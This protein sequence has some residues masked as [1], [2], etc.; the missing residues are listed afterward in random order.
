MKSAKWLAVF[1]LF[2][3]AFIAINAFIASW[4]IGLANQVI[5]DPSVFDSADIIALAREV[6]PALLF[7]IAQG[8]IF[9]VLALVAAYGMIRGKWWGLRIWRWTSLALIVSALMLILLLPRAWDYPAMLVAYGCIS[10]WM[11]REAEKA[12]A[13]AP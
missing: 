8:A 11:V 3:G 13:S 5:N 7:Q 10:W 4:G 9:A 6:R 1:V 12:N 2:I